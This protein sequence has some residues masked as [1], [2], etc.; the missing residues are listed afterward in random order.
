MSK[1]QFVD[2][3]QFAGEVENAEGAVLVD[4]TASWC[5]PCKALAPVLESVSARY[6]GR[7]KVVK[8]DADENANLAARYG[9]TGLPNLLFF[10]DGEVVNQA[11][12]YQSEEKLNRLLD[13]VIES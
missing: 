12:G 3:T 13:E 9:V 4:F 11:V 8:V 6:E 2:E 7:A 5:P 1:V 10:R